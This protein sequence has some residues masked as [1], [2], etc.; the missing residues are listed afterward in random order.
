LSGS[1]R[2]VLSCLLCSCVAAAQAQ[3]GPPAYLERIARQGAVVELSLQPIDGA[4]APLRAGQDV[5]V[6]FTVTDEA[7]ASPLSGVSLAA[8]FDRLRERERTTEEQCVGK[9][10]RFAEGSTLSRPEL[11]LNA[12]FVV[13]LN[14]DATIT[15]VDPRFGHGDTRLLEIVQLSSPAE[16]WAI[17]SDQ[18]KILV[19]LPD[20]GEVALVDTGSWKITASLKTGRRPGRVALQPDDAYLW[21]GYTTPEETSPSGVLVISTRDAAVVAT[22]PTGRGHHEIAFSDDSRYA[23]VTNALDGSVTIA[24]VRTLSK[25]ADV[26]TGPQPSAIAYSPL[27]HAAYV[28]NAGDGSIAAIDGHHAVAARMTADAGIGRLKFAPGGRFGIVANPVT[29]MVHVIDASTNRLVQS[30]KMDKGPEQ[31]AFSNKLA[32][33]GHR[34]SEVVLMLSLDSLGGPGGGLSAADFPGGQHPLGRRSRP[35]RADGIVQAAGEDAV[36][37][38]NPFDKAIYYYKEGMAAPMGNLAN[39]GRE[40]RAVLSVQRGLRAARPGRYETTLR[41]PA[42][43]EFDVA[44]MLDRPRVVHCF[45]L[46]V[47]RD[48]TAAAAAPAI[49]VEPAFELAGVRA[50]APVRLRFKV[51]DEATGAPK[52]GISDLRVLVICPGVWQSADFARERGPGEYETSVVPPE[53]GEYFVYVEAASEGLQARQFPA[54]SVK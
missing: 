33:I 53:S 48:P 29:D 14:Q 12:N 27:A 37:V 18:A 34:E 32:Y 3:S 46:I 51:S 10:K 40:P 20:S 28:A 4:A 21:V 54:L 15:V 6:R 49:R 22:I 45:T 17:T 41:L 1:R 8:W 52:R 16:D 19:S 2:A 26:P 36:L 24:D 39:Y 42:G 31:I 38:A 5:V 43:G 44:V 47:A 50:G 7:T 25:V 11:D 13:A 9:V 23:Y 35:S 30:G